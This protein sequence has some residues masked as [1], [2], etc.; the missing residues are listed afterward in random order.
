MEKILFKDIKEAVVKNAH[1]LIKEM[2][3]CS[4]TERSNC[5]VSLILSDGEQEQN[6]NMFNPNR[7]DPAGLTVE[8]L[9]TRGI[10]KGSVL[11]TDICRNGNYFN[12]SNWKANTD[13]SISVN[14][15][16]RSAPLDVEKAYAWIIDRVRESEKKD[17]QAEGNS[18][19]HLTLRI[20]EKYESKFKNNAAAVMMHHNYLS[21]LI[22]HTYRMLKMAMAACDVY[23]DLDRELMV[24]GTVLHDIGK[25]TTIDTDEAGTITM[26]LEGR[27]LEH[28]ME[29]V[30]IVDREAMGE[31]YNNKRLLLLEHM[32]ASH[33]GKLEYG[34]AVTPAIPE[35][36]MLH[37]I[38]MMDSRKGM[39]EEAYLDQEPDTISEKKIFG[40]DQ[41]R[42]YK[43][44]K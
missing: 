15:F 13:L 8:I 39:F 37:L 2:S 27:L 42:V 21:G 22:Y 14:D 5:Y 12:L 43:Q 6:I 36:E 25:V 29:G 41:S 35:A 34:A 31:N 40:L 4:P 38:D 44:A 19:A 24:C 26:Q 20:L 17:E 3:N 16:I 18:L 33:H 7:K 28:S 32:I 23:K 9:K 1:F 10:V 11:E 30:K